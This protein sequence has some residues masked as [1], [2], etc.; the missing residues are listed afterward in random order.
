MCPSRH[1]VW[2]GHNGT[3]MDSIPCLKET[4]FNLEPGVS[5]GFG[6]LRNEHLRCAAENWDNIE[7]Y[8]LEDFSLRYLNGELPP[9][10]YKVWGSVSTVPL[11]KSDEQDP[12]Q[13]CSVG[14]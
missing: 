6:G 11:F 12:S 3:C 1:H 5:G 4:L 13:I 9:W 2:G 14:I 10:F 8:R 7:M